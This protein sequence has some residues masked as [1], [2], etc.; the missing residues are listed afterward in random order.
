M[1][2]R[3]SEPDGDAPLPSVELSHGY[4]RPSG[5]STNDEE[6]GIA[7]PKDF[8]WSLPT[9]E[10]RRKAAARD[11]PLLDLLDNVPVSLSSG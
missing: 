8:V 3:S 1:R 9:M 6:S 11:R 7:T 2:K 10:G 4:L 5:C